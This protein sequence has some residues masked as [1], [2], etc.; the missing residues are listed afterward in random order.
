MATMKATKREDS[1]TRAARR[2]RSEGLTPAIMYGHGEA[3]VSLAVN[4]HEV[5]LAILHGER[6]LDIELE[7]KTENALIKDVQYDT[8]G[9]EILHVDLTRV[10]LDEMVEVY[11]PVILRGT[12]TGVTEGGMLQ[13]VTAEVAVECKVRD[14]PEEIRLDV[15]DM[16]IGDSFHAA[17]LVLPTEGTI[18]DDP[19]TVICTVS[20]VTEEEEAEEG[21]EEE[22]LLEPEVIGEKEEEEGEEGEKTEG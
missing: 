7:G 19:E 2:L 16:Q 1:G 20:F 17:D 21:A 6:V 10:N 15:N 11:V 13:Q 4:T 12:P 14:I 9:Q 3:S 5:E 18:V 22:A 8:F